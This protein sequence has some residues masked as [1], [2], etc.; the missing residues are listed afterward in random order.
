MVK[1]MTALETPTIEKPNSLTILQRIAEKDRTAVVDCVNTYGDF[2]WTLAQKFTDSTE[3]AEAAAE[4][5]F[6]DIWRYAERGGKI[7]LAENLLITRISLRRLMKPPAATI[8]MNVIDERARGETESM[9][10]IGERARGETDGISESN[11][12]PSV[13]KSVTDKPMKNPEHF[14]VL[15]AEDNEDACLMIK[16]TLEFANIKVTAAKTVAE[17]WRLA[18]SEYFDLYLLDSRFPD[19]DGL[20]LCRSL[21]E[22]A[23]HTPILIYSGNAYEADKQKGLAAG[24]NDYLT[25]PYMA[26][27]AVTIRQNIEQ[28]KK[29][30]RQTKTITA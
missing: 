17:A 28:N 11:G 18:Q 2:I 23:P 12:N 22:Y 6:L 29:T 10:V 30:A 1:I 4:K 24:A 3:E 16:I 19:G 7:R 14:C 5:I 26:D 9:D 25:K 20:D 27:I 15:Y 8:S 21:R 13:I